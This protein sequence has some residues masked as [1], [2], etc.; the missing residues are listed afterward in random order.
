MTLERNQYFFQ[1]GCIKLKVTVK[2]FIM[3]QTF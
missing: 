1:Q 3:L 2:T